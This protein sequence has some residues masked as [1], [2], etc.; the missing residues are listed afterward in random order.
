M[1]DERGYTPEEIERG[2]DRAWHF[3]KLGCLAT[4]FLIGAGTV[5]LL[6]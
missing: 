2:E 3:P 1:D 5:L 4:I 6:R